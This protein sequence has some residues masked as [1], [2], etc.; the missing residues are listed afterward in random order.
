MV[1]VHSQDCS[2]R[3]NCIRKKERKY[4]KQT[5]TGICTGLICIALAHIVQELHRR[6]GGL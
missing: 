5:S 3:G 4:R 6:Q 1:Q 2:H